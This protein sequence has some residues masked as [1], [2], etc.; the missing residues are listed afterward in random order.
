MRKADAKAQVITTFLTKS[1]ILGWIPSGILL[2]ITSVIISL[3]QNVYI[4]VKTLHTQYKLVLPWNQL[5]LIGWS[6]ETAFSLLAGCSYFL[7][8]S[9]F[10]SFFIGLCLYHEAFLNHIREMVGKIKNDDVKT[11]QSYYNVKS[12]LVNIIRFHNSAQR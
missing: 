11:A 5:T 7:I 3:V 2:S 4:D 8:N 6:F 10:I 12:L 1:L 9:T